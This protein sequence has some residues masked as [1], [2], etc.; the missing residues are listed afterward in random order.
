V[1]GAQRQ[2]HEPHA[3]AEAP[4]LAP[5]TM[6][7]PRTGARTTVPVADLEELRQGVARATRLGMIA[8]P[9]FFP[10]DVFLAL[11]VHPGASIV[12]C[13]LLRVVGTAFLYGVSRFASR[14]DLRPRAVLGAQLWGFLGG[15]T[16]IAL[17][18]L[19]LGGLRSEYVHGLSIVFVIQAALV[20]VRWQLSLRTT[21]PVLI[22]YLAIVPGWAALRHAPELSDP[23]T[24]A[25]FVASF[26][27]VVSLGAI[28]A[29]ASHGMWRLR[30]QVYEA[31]KLG[32]YRLTARI[33]QGGMN[34]IWLAWD[35]SLRRDVALKILRGADHDEA[36]IAR[37][38]REARAASRLRSPHTIRIHEFGA[39]DDG[40]YYIAMEYLPG[41]DLGT[42]VREHGPMPPARAAR[43]ARAAC[44]S[45]AE[46]HEAGIVHRDVKP[47]NLFATSVG[48]D[49]DFLKLLDFGIA[50]VAEPSPELTAAGVLR[51]T[52]A[53]MSPEVCRGAEA[54]PRSDLYSLGATLYFLLTGS[55]PFDQVSG[56]NLLLAHL[57]E[58]PMPPSVRLGSPVPRALE[59]VVLRCLSK[60]PEDR[61]ASARVLHDALGAAVDLAAWTDVE[62]R[63]FWA[64]HRPGS[65]MPA[66]QAASMREPTVAARPA[67]RRETA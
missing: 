29:I 46:A 15:G 32:R 23:S 33:G 13:A 26:L 19:Q 65:G 4:T 17:F 6:P 48:D 39:S 3:G 35:E 24:L 14:P 1:S 59:D 53:Y 43:F 37:F 56:G 51:G 20:P 54:E 8:W 64:Q 61:F 52:P 12:A 18:A 16:L 30:R 5:G 45:L 42:L 66:V 10:L 22:A 60:N 47:H 58:P 49:P 11:T 50:R 40:I 31:R 34:E 36:A 27:L 38:E 63:A 21:V 25:S 28:A 7:M 57:T 9:A 41:A 44:L 55:P 2:E 67:A 62:A